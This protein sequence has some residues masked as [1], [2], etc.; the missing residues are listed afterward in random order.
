VPV[1]TPLQLKSPR[2]LS[3]T[4]LAGRV[5]FVR[6]PPHLPHLLYLGGVNNTRPGLRFPPFFLR[7]IALMR[8]PWGWCLESI[9]S[10]LPLDVDL[11]SNGVFSYAVK[12]SK[13]EFFFFQRKFFSLPPPTVVVTFPLGS[14]EM[15]ISRS[16]LRKKFF[17]P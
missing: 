4:F 2:K 3:P 13:G 1:Y 6:S 14:A 8:F 11:F 15:S 16:Y 12:I 10:P 17:F 9:D 7:N 5:T